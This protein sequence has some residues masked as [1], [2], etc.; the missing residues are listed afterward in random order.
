MA[1]TT[2]PRGQAEFSPALLG[3][4]AHGS[5]IPSS[6]SAP[7]FRTLLT[8]RL[9]GH[10]RTTPTAAGRIRSAGWPGAS[11]SQAG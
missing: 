11:P 1:S 7:L 4:G 6:N 10:S 2:T 5:S 8:A 3:G 9:T